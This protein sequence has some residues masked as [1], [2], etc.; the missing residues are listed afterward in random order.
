MGMSLSPPPPAT[1]TVLLGAMVTTAL[2]QLPAAQVKVPL[3]TFVPTRLPAFSTTLPLVTAP[4]MLKLP[5][6]RYVVPVPLLVTEPPVKLPLPCN[7]ML[8]VRALNS[9][10]IWLNRTPPANTVLPVPADLRQVPKLL[11]VG[12]T[13]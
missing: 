10:P 9:P 4:L 2:F 6:F 7:R 11:N 3:M 8:P 12:S 1:V 13:M 5:P